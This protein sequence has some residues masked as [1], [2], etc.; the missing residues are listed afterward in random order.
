[1]NKYSIHITQSAIND[2]IEVSNYIEFTLFNPKA[3]AD[4]LDEAQSAF[5]ALETNPERHAII[6]DPFLSAHGFRLLIIKN[7]LAFYLIDDNSKS[8]HIVRFL[9]SRQNWTEILNE[10]Y[11][12]D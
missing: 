6:D 5:Q 12:L 3:A 7:Y 10:G 1:M 11:S 9:Y 8:V 2:L 4:L